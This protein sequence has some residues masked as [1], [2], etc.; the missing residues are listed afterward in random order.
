MTQ[1]YYPDGFRT[2]T[3]TPTLNNG[4]LFRAQRA[5]EAFNGSMTGT[6][7]FDLS[8]NIHNRTQF[9][10]LYEQQDYDDDVDERLRVRRGG[11]GVASAT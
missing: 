9:R 8:D 7:R 1:D 2:L 4:Y 5:Y 3:A 10:Y 11:R 6:F